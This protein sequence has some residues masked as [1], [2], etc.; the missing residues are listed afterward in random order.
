MHVQVQAHAD[1]HAVTHMLT[2]IEQAIGLSKQGTGS[3]GGRTD[4]T[5]IMGP[6]EDMLRSM[7]HPGGAGSKAAQQGKRSS[8][9]KDPESGAPLAERVDRVIAECSTRQAAVSQLHLELTK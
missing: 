8:L 9:G 5:Q 3:P 7:T 6:L 4:M 1:R 2:P